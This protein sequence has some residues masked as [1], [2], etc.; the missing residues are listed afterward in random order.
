MTN[1]SGSDAAIRER[2]DYL[3]RFA[4]GAAP[5]VVMDTA[6]EVARL[7]RRLAELEAVDGH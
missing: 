3:R 1:E 6:D 4:Y 7:E 2:I 5:A